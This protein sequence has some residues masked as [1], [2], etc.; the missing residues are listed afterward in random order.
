MHVSER[1]FTDPQ[2]RKYQQRIFRYIVARW[3]YSPNILSWELFNEID[4][5]Q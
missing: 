4:E 5:L 1:H 3:G 2:A